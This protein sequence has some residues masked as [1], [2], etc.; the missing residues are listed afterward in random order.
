[1]SYRSESLL[2]ALE[3]NR[4]ALTRFLMGRLGCAETAEDIL[5][6]LSERLLGTPATTEV[7][8]KKAYLFRAA[9]NA[10]NSSTRLA[11]TR[12]F[13]E[14]AA[15]N[16]FDQTDQ[17]DPERTL[18]GRQMLA[19][20]EEAIAELPILTQRIFIAFKIKGE[21]QQSIAQR[22]GVSL[23]TVEKRLASAVIHCQQRIEAQEAKDDAGGNRR[24]NKT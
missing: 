1:M 18:V 15:A 13:N 14:A 8:N 16:Q 5:Q 7:R 23:S 12:A 10:A 24:K 9:A 22:F 4:A 17:I 21:T 3:E 11:Q 6:S 2:V 19:T 20:V